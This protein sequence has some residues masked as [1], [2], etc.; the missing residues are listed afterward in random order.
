MLLSG[1][2]SV[3]TTSVSPQT[4]CV[5]ISSDNVIQNANLQGFGSANPSS[6]DTCTDFTCT[7]NNHTSGDFCY[8]ATTQWTQNI[9]THNRDDGNLCILWGF[10]TPDNM[11]N[12]RLVN[13]NFFTETACFFYR[14]F[15]GFKTIESYAA[16]LQNSLNFALRKNLFYDD[17]EDP[18]NKDNEA[19]EWPTLDATIFSLSEHKC[20]VKG[21]D[22][23]FFVYNGG[24]F[25]GNVVPWFRVYANPN[26]SNGHVVIEMVWVTEAWYN[27]G[28]ETS[29]VTN[30][31]IS[32][33]KNT[34]LYPKFLLGN[35]GWYSARNVHGFGTY[36]KSENDYVPTYLLDQDAEKK[37]TQ[38][39]DLTYEDQSRGVYLPFTNVMVSDGIA[40][41]VRYPYL[42]INSAL[43]TKNRA[44]GVQT[45]G[46][47]NSTLV[48]SIFAF[49]VRATNNSKLVAVADDDVLY[50]GRIQIRP[51]QTFDVL[52]FK[53]T[54]EDS[55]ESLVV[56]NT[57]VEV[58]K[59]YNEQRTNDLLIN[60]SAIYNNDSVG[61]GESGNT[62]LL[63]GVTLSKYKDYVNRYVNLVWGGLLNLNDL[64]TERLTNLFG[65]QYYKFQEHSL[66]TNS[67]LERTNRANT[68]VHSV[69]FES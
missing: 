52:D 30:Y 25:T 49:S 17:F 60:F 27:G 5:F 23:A 19:D 2:S 56:G 43:L 57:L 8:Y 54:A 41:T 62:L 7:L 35:C 14:P 20:T 11:N 33:G 24:V 10:D 39:I 44:N 61:F 38:N 55:G 32:I 4:T 1:P 16:A 46:A 65:T 3:P 45:V 34:N 28:F 26:F 29:P 22:Q 31:V 58:M 51:N 59:L 67:P 63:N 42:S 37:L 64:D 66:L 50:R 12:A 18:L 15:E 48:D 53:L 36:R 9:H 69:I 13:G 47:P 21:E 6:F 40:N 68:I